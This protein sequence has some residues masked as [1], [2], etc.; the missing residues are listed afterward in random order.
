MSSAT[1]CSTTIRGSWNTASPFAMP[2]TSLRPGQPQR[3]GAA[4]AA[5]AG[6]VD[7]PR[8]ADHL[9]QHHRDGL[10][11]LDLDVLVAARL[12]VLDREHADRALEPD[13]R[14]A[15][16]AV[17]ALLAGLR[18][19]RRK[20]DARAASARLRI[21]PSAAMV[22]TRPSPI[23]SRGDVHG[24]LAQ[25]VGCEQLEIIVAQQVDRA[26]VAAHRLRDEVD[27]AVE[28]ALR[29]A[30][31]RHDLVET[32]QDLAGGSGGGGGHITRAIRCAAAVSR[33]EVGHRTAA[34]GR[35]LRLKPGSA[36]SKVHVEI[37]HL[38][39]DMTLAVYCEI[40]RN[41]AEPVEPPHM[42][43]SIPALNIAGSARSGSAIFASSTWDELRGTSDSFTGATP[44]AT[45]TIALIII[46]YTPVTRAAIAA[47][48]HRSR[49]VP[50]EKVSHSS[51]CLAKCF[52]RR[53]LYLF[54]E[55]RY[56]LVILTPAPEPN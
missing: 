19:G 40:V 48:K 44:R 35:C 45:A 30:A 6:A 56:S 27:D 33:E 12:G 16:E 31:L 49:S 20:R 34:W 13:D 43:L 53:R 47:S 36:T 14:H 54:G 9:G 8:A 55:R 4:Q 11:R 15:G 50:D 52:R 29:R 38:A 22:P 41:R 24:F 39:R 5:A 2:E 37:A 1:V 21:R 18:A 10:Q 3:A 17:E 42:G 23:L 25:A 28:L 32:G 46:T 26:D 51:G 7:Q